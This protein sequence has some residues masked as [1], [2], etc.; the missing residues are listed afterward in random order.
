MHDYHG[1][2]EGLQKKVDGAATRYGRKVWLTEIAITLWGKPPSM[3]E[4]SAYME[5]FSHT[6]T[7]ARM[8]SDMP[9]SLRA[10]PPMN[11][12]VEAICWRL[13]DQRPSPP[14]ARFTG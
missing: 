4:Q 9:G 12:T 13:T 14:S 6:S 1:S 8:S 3:D 7:P 2:V 11:K 5:D 10:T